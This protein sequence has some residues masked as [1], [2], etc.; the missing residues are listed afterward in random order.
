MTSTRSTLARA[1]GVAAVAAALAPGIVAAA[2][3]NDG[4][5]RLLGRAV[6][7]VNTYAP[8]PTSGNFYTG[9]QNADHLPDAEPARRGHL[10]DRRGSPR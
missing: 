9:P 2:K 6:L 3:P 8:G 1:A 5:P 7:D 10:V 4:P